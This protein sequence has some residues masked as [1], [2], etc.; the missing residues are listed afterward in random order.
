MSQTEPASNGFPGLRRF[1][2]TTTW[3]L[4]L[5]VLATVPLLVSAARFG[6]DWVPQGDE[7]AIT[8]R[9]DDL[10]RAET[11]LV[12]MPSTVGDAVGEQV[13]HPGPLESQAIG[14]VA[15]VIDDPRVAVATVA[16]VNLAS[17]VVALLWAR[18]LGGMPLLAG[19][20]V[21]MAL[22]LWSLRGPILATPYNPYAALLPYLACLVSLVAVWDHRRWAATVAVV[23]GSW[24]AQ[25]HLT[26]SGP[27]A[28]AVA[29]MAV[30]AA[31]RWLS[32]RWSGTP[33]PVLAERNRLLVG[34]GA[35]VTVWAAPIV[36]IVTNDGGNVR[37]VLRASGSLDESTLGPATALD[38]VIHAVGVRP[39]WAQA[40]TGSIDLLGTPSAV[41]YSSAALV[42][43]AALVTAV[44][45]RR[46]KPAVTAA[47]VLSGASLLA[48]G[49]LTAKI[50][51]AFFN[52]VALHNY[53]W[54]WPASA[55][56]WVAAVSGLVHLVADRVPDRPSVAPMLVATTAVVLV[57]ALASFDSPH[58]SPGTKESTYTK[59]LAPQ[60]EAA[61]DADGAYVIDLSEEIATYGQGTGL[62]YALEHAGF[63]VRVPARFEAAFG[64]H[65]LT[66]GPRDKIVVRIS[67]DQVTPPPGSRVLA[68]L[69]PDDDLLER[70][71]SAEQIVIDEI[72]RRGGTTVGDGTRISADEAR[73]WVESGEYLAF[74]SFRL[75]DPALAALP[76]SEQL[77]RFVQTPID[78]VTVH[79]EPAG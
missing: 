18:R 42:L 49:F 46:T 75:V 52:A 6:H 63:D 71:S 43:V 56:L 25:A 59:A 57:V 21:V 65:R 70:R 8:L 15:A 76:A 29:A 3:T 38:I 37:A 35:L 45:C 30:V 48:G 9:G 28:A 1:R 12:G 58:R 72:E 10:F 40:G 78:V 19:S 20:S 13:H 61:L 68:V 14:L 64:A 27:V 47:V 44:A 53:V 32:P 55:V 73:A 26:T 69:Q 7:A 36:D 17:V 54:L 51:D 41:Q 11:P 33:R 39:V 50:P 67:R 77:L 31:W 60:V 2:S 24:A 79:L 4:L 23:F 16:L 66:D 5:V 34:A 74:L 62:L 22:L